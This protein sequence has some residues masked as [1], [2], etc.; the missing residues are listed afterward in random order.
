MEEIP[1]PTTWDVEYP[2]IHGIFTGWWLQTFFI[3]AAERFSWSSD[4]ESAGKNIFYF[5]PYLGR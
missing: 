4:W 1:R 3:S 5:H 2:V